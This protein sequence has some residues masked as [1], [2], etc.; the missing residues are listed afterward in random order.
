MPTDRCP[1]TPAPTDLD[2]ADLRPT[3]LDPTDLHP[4]ELRPTVAARTGEDG[5]L[6]TEYGLL[7]VLGATITGLAIKWAAGG[8]IWELFAAVLDRAKA[9]VG[10]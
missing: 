5:S 1:T 3:D 8:A 2:P 6:V 4:N 10:A 7:A 9:I